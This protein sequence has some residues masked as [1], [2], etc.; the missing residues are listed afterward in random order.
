MRLAKANAAVDK[1]RVIGL[2]GV[3]GDLAC[4]SPREL[5]ARI[6][7]ILRR[8]GNSD[9]PPP[10]ASPF[11]ID[12]ARASIRFHGSRLELTR[13]EYQLLAALLE[14]P[15]RVFSR[16]QL[17]QRIWQQPHPSDERTID[18]HIKA[19]RAKIRSIVPDADPIRTHRG[20]GYS[21]DQ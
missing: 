18:T 20:L 8:S 6:R 14:Q 19:L 13:A 2:A 16:A 4:R 5:V 1:K 17:M 11:E 21:L 7:V 9:Q 10:S 15:G 3:L 12:P